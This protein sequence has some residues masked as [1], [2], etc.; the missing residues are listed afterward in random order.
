MT[1]EKQ[2]FLESTLSILIDKLKWDGEEN[3]DEM[4][5]DDRMAFENMRK[6]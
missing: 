1:S 4:D 5:P 6:V 2:S 3:P